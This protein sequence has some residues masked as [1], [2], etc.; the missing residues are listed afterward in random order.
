MGWR[1]ALTTRL[2]RL[3]GIAIVSIAVSAATAFLL[4]PLAV[5]AMVRALQVTV[6]A[7]VWL[8]ASLGAGVDWWTIAGSVGREAASVLVSSGAVGVLAA[9]LLVGAAALYGLQRLLGHEE[10]SR[11]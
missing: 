9:L 2:A 4:L 5:S 7:C 11:R 10:E 1:R 3:A 6:N 8:A